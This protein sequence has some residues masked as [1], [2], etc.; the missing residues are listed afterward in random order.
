MLFKVI[1]FSL[2]ELH[3]IFSPSVPGEWYY[4]ALFEVLTVHVDV[5]NV[6]EGTFPLTRVKTPL[7]YSCIEAHSTYF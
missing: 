5:F 6:R 4:L 2:L 7:W 1:V 3:I